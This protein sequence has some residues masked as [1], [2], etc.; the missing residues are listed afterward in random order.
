MLVNGCREGI[1]PLP[2]VAAAWMRR[3]CSEFVDIGPSLATTPTCPDES[4]GAHPVETGPS[5]VEIGPRC[6]ENG[7]QVSPKLIRPGPVQ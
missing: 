1:T 7:E 5:V 3:V 4:E 6:A 2:S